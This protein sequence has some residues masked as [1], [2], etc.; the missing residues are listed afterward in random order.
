MGDGAIK[1]VRRLCRT[2][3]DTTGRPV[4]SN[5]VLQDVTT[6]KQAE[7][8]RT[9]LENQ[10]LGAQKMEAI[11]HLAGGLAHDFNN[12]LTVIGGNASL[13]QIKVDRDSPVYKFLSEI[14]SAVQSA[15]NLTRQLLAF[16]RKQVIAPK[17]LDLNGIIIRLRRMLGRV[18]GEDLEFTTVL[19]E[20][21]GHV[22]FDPGQMEQILVNLVVNAR[23]AMIGGGK[24]IFETLNVNLDENYCKEHGDMAPGKYVMLAVSDSGAGMSEEVKAHM[25]E[26]FYTTKGPGNGTGLGLAMVYGAVKQNTGIIEVYSELNQGTVIK[27]YLPCVDQV[28]EQAQPDP[29]SPWLHGTET[30]VL[31]ED[32]SKVRSL[33]LQILKLQGYRV[34]GFSNGVEALRGV[35]TLSEHIDLLVTDVVMPHM[36]GHVLSEKMKALRPGIR[37]LFTSGFTH[38]VIFRDGVIEDGIEFLAKPYTL[39]VLAKRVREVLDK[40]TT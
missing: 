12:L 24:L 27:I 19:A 3:Y 14:N 16:S 36:N 34:H 17:V 38:N 20:D 13:G 9:R 21:L 31:V 22:C 40:G 5:G 8:A 35:E 6:I 7:E 37:V 18:V 4:R 30:I 29:V 11:G 25:F 2:E 32:D 39:E 15:A 28:P 33:A 10:L 26:P 23:D 1:H